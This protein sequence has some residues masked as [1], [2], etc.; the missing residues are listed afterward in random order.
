MK[1]QLGQATVASV[2]FSVGTFANAQDHS[3]LN[4]VPSTSGIVPV[5]DLHLVNPWVISRISGGSSWI[6]DNGTGLR[7]LYNRT[8]AVL[9]TSLSV[10]IATGD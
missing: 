5:S 8:G 7:T 2:A 10:R 9:R 1:K 6:S 3:H 4:Q